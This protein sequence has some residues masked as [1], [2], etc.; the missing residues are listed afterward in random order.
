MRLASKRDTDFETNI[1]AFCCSIIYHLQDTKHV[2]QMRSC[3]VFVDLKKNRIP[4]IE[5]ISFIE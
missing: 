1:S 4:E 5:I 2:F 3:R